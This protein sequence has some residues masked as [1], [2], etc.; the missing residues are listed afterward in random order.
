MRHV[1]GFDVARP[2]SIGVLVFM[3]LPLVFL[4]GG[5]VKF[6]AKTENGSS[7]TLI[8]PGRDV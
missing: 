6:N 2:L 5:K 3:M 7:F 4:H 1:R 8:L